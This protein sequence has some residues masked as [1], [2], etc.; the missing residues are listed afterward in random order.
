MFVV[1]PPLM[2]SL[3]GPEV[4]SLFWRRSLGKCVRHIGTKDKEVL[5]SRD[6]IKEMGA[7][8]VNAIVICFVKHLNSLSAMDGCDRPLKN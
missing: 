7:C 6:R 5:T 1:H 2:E 4:K 8:L 3:V